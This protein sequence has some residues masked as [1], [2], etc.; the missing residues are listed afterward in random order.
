MHTDRCGNSHRQS[1]VQREAG[2]MLKYKILCIEIQRTWYLKC[3]I[4]PVIIAATG[5]ATKCLRKNLKDLQGKYSINSLQKTSHVICK[6]LQSE[7]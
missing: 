2:K 3:G 6:V 5:I 7:S 4:I 1:V